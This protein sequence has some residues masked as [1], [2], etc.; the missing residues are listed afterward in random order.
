[1]LRSLSNTLVGVRQVTERNAGRH[2][3]G[4]DGEIALTVTARATLT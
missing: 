3:A 1:M 2:T 4:I